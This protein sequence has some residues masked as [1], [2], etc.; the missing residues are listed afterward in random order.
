M[1]FVKLI[2]RNG[3]GIHF[4][5]GASLQ[6]VLDDTSNGTEFGGRPMASHKVVSEEVSSRF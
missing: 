2:P 6:N 5:V 1:V 3:G 4:F